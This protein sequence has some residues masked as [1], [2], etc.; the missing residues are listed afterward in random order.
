MDKPEGITSHD[1]VQR[2]RRALRIRSAGHTGT[3]DPFATGLLVVLLGRATR[4]ARFVEAQAKTYHA[5]ARLGVRTDTDDRTGVVLE[6]QPL[7][8]LE[9]QDVRRALEGFLGPGRQRPPAYSAKHLDGERSYRRARR[10]EAVAPAEVGVTVHAVEW[11]RWVPPELE[12][13][14]TASAGTYIRALA[15][16]LGAALG[17]GGHLSALRREAIGGLRVEDAVPLD[18][19]GPGSVQSPVSVLGHLPA[20]PLDAVGRGHAVHGRTVPEAA[21]EPGA[22]ARLMAGEELVA[23]ARREPVGWQPVVVLGTP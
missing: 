5:I 23:V 8:R 6:E 2:V 10:G 9:E 13:R 15:R 21:G 7:E 4:L 19:V 16:D 1:V 12:F 14:I 3:L 18:A 11:L 22:L 20:V 17:V